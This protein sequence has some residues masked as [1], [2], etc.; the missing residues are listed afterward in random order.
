MNI[1][2]QGCKF[3]CRKQCEN[4]LSC[5]IGKAIN[6]EYVKKV[7]HESDCNHVKIHTTDNTW[8]QQS[9]FIKSVLKSNV[10]NGR[11]YIVKSKF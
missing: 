8:K 4:S 1:Y 10:A 3:N 7:L 6:S 2:L 11:V 9:D 5:N